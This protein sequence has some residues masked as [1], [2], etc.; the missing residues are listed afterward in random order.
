MD[1]FRFADVI[2]DMNCFNGFCVA[3]QPDDS[4]LCVKNVCT[5]GDPEMCLDNYKGIQIQM[6]DKVGSTSQAMWNRPEIPI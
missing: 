5:L 1:Y 6:Q 4:I 3:Q 2:N